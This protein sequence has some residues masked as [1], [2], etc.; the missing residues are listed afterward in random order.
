MKK[1]KLILLS[2]LLFSCGGQE[3]VSHLDSISENIVSSDISITSEELNS[4]EELTSSEDSFVSMEENSSLE[5]KEEIHYTSNPSSEPDYN[6]QLQVVNHIGDIETVWN[7]Y[8]GDG[9]KVAVIDSGFDYNHP[10]FFKA[11]GSSMISEESIYISSDHNGNITKTIG[12]EHVGITDGDSHGTMCAGLLAS[13]VNNYGMSGIAP[14]CD[15]VLIKIDKKAYSMAEAFRYCGDIGVKVVSVS[16]GAYPSPSG[17]NSGD[18][19]FKAGLD[20]STIFNEAINYAYEKD[21]TIVSASGNSKSTTLSYPAGC[22]NVIGAGGLNLNSSTLIWD[23]GYEGS[24]YNGSKVYVDVFA[25]S[26]GIYAPGYDVSKSKSTYWSDGKGTSFAAP[27]IAGA[28]TLYFQKYESAT[29]EDFLKALEN[30]CV[31]VSTYNANKNMGYGRLDVGKLLNIDED[32]IN[33]DYQ[34]TTTKNKEAT[35]IHFVDEAGWDIRTL[36]LYDLVFE[37]G[38]GYY[39]FEKFLDYEYGRVKTSSYTLEG[40]NRCWAYSDEDCSGD[41]FLCSGNKDHA[42]QTEYN[43][44]LPYWVKSATYQ[45]VNNHNW[46][47]KIGLTFNESDGKN[48]TINNYFWYKGDSD[49]G[50]SRVVDSTCYYDYP[51]VNVYLNDEKIDTS[52]IYDYYELDNAYLD[53]NKTQKYHRSVLKKDTYLYK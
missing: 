34:V 28:A 41:Y 27:I 1:T 35:N 5:T 31:D 6:K 52:I 50:V 48:K 46:L 8:R 42:K 39:D 45:F 21:V 9:V 3:V 32:I 38:Y 13:S 19:I 37:E 25:P 7:Y 22:D 15:L 36:H 30:T 33:D 40:E 24:N 23:N 43:Y 16:L 47:P 12:K 44:Y 51:A 14:N 2:F 10:D 4:S 29:N 11:D 53:I 18:I 49:T 20:L 26:A 17:A